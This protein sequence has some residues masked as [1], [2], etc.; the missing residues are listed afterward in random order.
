MDNKLYV[1]N[2]PYTMRDEDLREHFAR[3]GEVASAKVMTD[4]ETGRSKGF[5]FVEM[6]SG[7]DARSA[8]SGM[9]GQSFDGRALVVNEARP[10]EERS[11]GFGGGGQGGYRGGRSSY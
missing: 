3:F 9:H 7:E 2:L 10:R 11:G 4:R 1:G 6:A 5:A 8:I